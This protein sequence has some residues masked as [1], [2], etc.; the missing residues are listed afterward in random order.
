LDWYSSNSAILAH[1]DVHR[2]VA[3]FLGDR[4]QLDA[5]LRQLA[6]IELEFGMIAEEAAE[7]MNEHDFERS[8]LRRSGFDHA[9]ELGSPVVRRGRTR[10]DKGLD[11]LVAP[12]GAVGFA[13][14]ALVGDG[15]VVL[16][17]PRRRD[18]QVQGGAQHYGHSKTPLRLSAG[19][20]QFIEKIAEPRLEYVDLG[21]RDRYARGPIVHHAPRLDI[22][23]DRSSDARPR[24][25][26]DV[27]VVGQGA[28]FGS[29]TT[30]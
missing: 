20:E 17:L 22:V 7:R 19:P 16:R 12:R 24:T 3:D 18:A 5:V 2:I 4:D 14:P 26:N 28:S 8:G 25:R 23:F 21:V 29:G 15:D 9:L 30:R 6:D 10:L 1:H 13:L 11:E 27:D